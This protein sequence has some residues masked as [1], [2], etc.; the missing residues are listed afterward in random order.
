MASPLPDP[1][2]FRIAVTP[3]VF[4][5]GKRRTER[6]N[7][8]NLKCAVVT[9]VT[10]VL[11]GVSAFARPQTNEANREVMPLTTTSIGFIAESYGDTQRSCP[12][13][14]CFALKTVQI[15]AGGTLQDFLKTGVLAAYP[16]RTLMPTQTDELIPTRKTLL[17]RLRDLSDQASWREFYETYWRLIYN[18]ARKSGFSDAAAQDIVQ[19]TL[20]T[21]LRHMPDFHY[22]PEV[23]SFKGWLLQITRSRMI[24][25]LRRKHSKQG[26]QFVPREEE[27]GTSLLESQSKDTELEAIWDEE[28]RTHHI[29]LAL[30]KVKGTVDARQFQ[31][32]YLHVIEEVPALQVAR[33]L[34][35]K[36][37]EVY[38][39][40]YKVSA[41]LKKEIK[42]LERNG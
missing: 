26:G 36:L 40:K 27:L 37:P 32:F 18:V 31:M 5:F 39:A 16:I 3:G 6:I 21:L 35:A 12:F 8:V 41:R 20:V 28:W 19:E 23:G 38:F 22:K 10:I 4:C 30:E 15:R 13:L 24:D 25:A 11:I 42:R 7:A 2:I 17:S 34:G 29:D 33:R 14:N 1:N 9:V